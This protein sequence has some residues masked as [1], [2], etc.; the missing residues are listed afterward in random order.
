MIDD[1]Y[2]SMAA[3]AQALRRRTERQALGLGGALG[4]AAEPYPHQL[5]TVRRILGDTRIRH[6][7]SDE[8]G[9]GKTV[10]ALMVLNALRL[11]DPDHSA[12]IVAPD[13]LIDQ[14]QSECWTRCHVQATVVDDSGEAEGRV[15]LVRPQSLV[16][17]VYVLDPQRTTLLL[18]D[19]PQTMPVEIGRA[20][21]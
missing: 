3:G 16:S 18:V 21:V 9:L 7:I 6:L 2:L 12:V 13:R 15:Q 19:E 8:V 11:Q 10:E 17:G 5:A 14:W 1:P 4:V 20:H